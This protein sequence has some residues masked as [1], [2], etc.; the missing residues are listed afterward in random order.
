M[1]NVVLCNI[2]FSSKVKFKIKCPTMSLTKYII[3]NTHVYIYTH[4]YIYKSTSSFKI[5]VKTIEYICYIFSNKI[6]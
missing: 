3:I 2:I 4:I 1:Y 5:H 6:F